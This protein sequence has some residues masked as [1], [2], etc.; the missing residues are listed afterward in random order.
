MNHKGCLG[1]CS[2]SL[3]PE[4]PEELIACLKEIGINNV[5]LALGPLIYE[6]AWAGGVEKLKD[7]G[8]SIVSGMFGTKDEDYT[9]LETIRKTGG[10]V[11]D[12]TWDYNWNH[13]LK[14]IPMARAAGVKL[15]SFH[16]G[17]LPET[18]EDPTYEKLVNRLTQIAAAFGE[19][20]VDLAFETGQE[21][22]DTLK[23]FLDKLAAPNVGVNFDP[24]N[25]ILYGKG[26]PVTAVHVLKPYLKQ[27][28]IKDALPAK[29]ADQWG[30][31]VVVGT[32]D[33]RWREFFD[34][35]EEFQGYRCIEREAGNQRVRDI[36]TAAEYCSELL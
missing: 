30:E 28:H 35:I 6:K 25:M 9:S 7:A 34:A 12:E 17:F 33:V 22:A 11:P 1:V 36:K 24:A 21:D 18:E 8:L 31:E 27:I 14:V 15:V 2:W 5:Q 4:G 20:G 10:I 13:I 32:G 26:D 16:A 19:E 29:E 23:G 3:Q